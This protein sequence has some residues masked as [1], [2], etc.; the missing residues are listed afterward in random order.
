MLLGDLY[1]E[2]RADLNLPT[3]NILQFWT[4]VLFI[5]QSAPNFSSIH[6]HRVKMFQGRNNC[7]STF[8]KTGKKK[9]TNKK[10]MGTERVRLIWRECARGKKSPE[11]PCSA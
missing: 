9:Q 6:F 1:E 8:A 2:N 5:C 7:K 3:L 4:A 11:K 10:K